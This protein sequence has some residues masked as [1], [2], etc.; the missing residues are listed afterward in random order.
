ME[1]LSW[2]HLTPWRPSLVAGRTSDGIDWSRDILTVD[3]VTGERA[4]RFVRRYGETWEAWDIEGF[5]ELFG[6]AVTY[7]AHPDEIVEGRAALRRYVEKEQ[8]AQ[9]DVRVR[10]GRPL[11]EDDRVMAEF[12]VIA[13]EDASI[14]GC[15]IAHLDP[16]GVC[17]AFREYWFDLEGQCQPF[18]GWGA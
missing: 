1:S 3:A 9:G 7:V 16:Q 10:M 13:G 8:E 12:W 14:A 6:E 15:L 2:S 5:V 11:A 18:E 4:E 17:T